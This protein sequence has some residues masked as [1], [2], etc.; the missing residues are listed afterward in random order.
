MARAHSVAW[1][2]ALS[3]LS[4][5]ARADTPPDDPFP[6]PPALTSNVDFWSRVFGEWGVGQVVI[7]DLEYPAIVYEVVELEG[8]TDGGY[9]PAQRA[10]IEGLCNYWEGYLHGLEHKI[11]TGAGLTDAD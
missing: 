4:V 9:T 10:R 1:L 11:E 7:H 5:W 8:P 3:A 2:L 6:E